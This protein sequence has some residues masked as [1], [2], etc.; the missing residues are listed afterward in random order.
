MITTPHYAPQYPLNQ[1]KTSQGK[2]A[3]IELSLTSIQFSFI[4]SR[5]DG[6]NRLANA[7]KFPYFCYLS[8]DNFHSTLYLKSYFKPCLSSQ[9][10]TEVMDPDILVWPIKYTPYLSALLANK[11]SDSFGRPD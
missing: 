7:G 4:V 9:C 6:Y 2:K 1:V 8:S 5:F 3:Q 11:D 10:P